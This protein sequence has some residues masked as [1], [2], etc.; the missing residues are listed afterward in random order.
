MAAPQHQTPDEQLLDA[1]R[2]HVVRVG[3]TVRRRPGPHAPFVHAVLRRL[4]ERGFTAAPRFLGLDEQGRETLSFLPGRSGHGL[5]RPGTGRLSELAAWTAALHDALAG[6]P[7]AGSAPTVCHRDLAPWNLIVD[8]APGVPLAFVDFDDAA[9][10]RPAQDVGY[11]LWTFLRLGTPEVTD[12]EQRHDLESFLSAYDT[13]ARTPVD[14]SEMP[15]A[16]RTEMTRV[17][18][19]RRTQ[20]SSADPGLAEFAVSRV[21]EIEHDLTWLAARAHWWT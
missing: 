6:T 9:P 14:R 16:I 8:P 11:L 17:L 19:M 5:R 13:V 7:E 2:P 18:Q 12:D 15:A 21:A 1:T 10:G 4:E 20:R 3:D